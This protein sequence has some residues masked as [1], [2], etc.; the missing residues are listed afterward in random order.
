MDGTRFAIMDFP[1]PG[2]PMHKILEPISFRAAKAG[3]LR[4]EMPTVAYS[5][6][7]FSS[8]AQS[9]G[10]SERR[11][12]EDAHRYAAERGF[13]LNESLG[14]DRGLS[15]FSGENLAAGV[16]GE[17][18]RQARD[19]EIAKGS[20]LIV[21]NPDRISRQKFATAYARFAGGCGAPRLPQP[22]R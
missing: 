14:V 13:V 19:G 15:G 9:D 20:V 10:D 16:L 5:Y 12:L 22:F 3:I 1:D 2:G 11:Q 7:R 21:E 8:V 4:E 6:A 17:F 18:V